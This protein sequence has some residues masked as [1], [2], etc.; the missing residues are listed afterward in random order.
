MKYNLLFALCCLL[1]NSVYSQKL[2][3]ATQVSSHTQTAL[4][5]K[6]NLPAALVKN[7]A[8]LYKVLYK[9][10][11]IHGM[12]DT[13][14]GLVAI[15]DVTGEYPLLCYQ[16]GTA[17]DRTGVPSFINPDGYPK[18]DPIGV[19]FSAFGYVVAAADYLGLGDS[20]GFHPY[21]HLETEA[22]AAIDLLFATQELMQSQNSSLNEQ[23]FISGYSQGGHGAMAAHQK[24]QEDFSNDFTVTASAPM[25]GP[26]SISGVMTDLILQNEEYFLPSYI[27][28][29]FLS[30]DLAYDLFEDTEE[31]FKQPYAMTIDSFYREEMDLFTLNA[32]L[33]NQ[34]ITNT[35]GS[36]PKAML[37]DSI[38]AVTTDET[39]PLSIALHA[40]DNINWVP[41]APTRLYYCTADD[42][43]PFRNS[44]VADSIFQLKN[45]PDLQA[46]DVNPTATHGA[47][48][49]PAVTSALFFFLQF[50]SIK[51]STKE[52]ILPSSTLRIS[53]NPVRDF[54][55]LQWEGKLSS[56]ELYDTY[57]HQVRQVLIDL[58]ETQQLDMSDLPAG[59]YFLLGRDGERKVFKKLVKE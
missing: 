20:D 56:L 38:L 30:Y 21:V 49:N 34:L 39:H 50:Q 19:I 22:S 28:N 2:I 45:V 23:L 16:H 57:G 42:Q 25:S 17:N 32:R 10:N 37:Q 27:P 9:T 31:Y 7:G 54:V 12:P 41:E 35:G 52:I 36:F 14:S 8:T 24:I 15:P 13:A 33:I 26:Y 18:G 1:A 44:V 47:C 4:T 29:T 43:V 46:I 51:V 5:N 58:Q 11:N 59:M 6:F 40:N 55:D 3:S 48:V 53:P